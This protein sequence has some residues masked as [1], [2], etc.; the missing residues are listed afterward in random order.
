GD[1]RIAV[2]VPAGVEP[3]MVSQGSVCIAG[4]SLT[5]AGVTQGGG[6]IEVAVIPATLGLTTLGDLKA[7]SPVNI[8]AD[9]TTKAVVATVLRVMESRR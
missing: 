1:Y 6:E 8:E 2:R 9:A 7:G 3:F 5:L 4:V